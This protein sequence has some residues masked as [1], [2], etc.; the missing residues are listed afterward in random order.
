MA[1]FK[2]T[3]A[4]NLVISEPDYK[5]NNEELNEAYTGDGTIIN[6]DFLNDAFKISSLSF[7]LFK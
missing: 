1:Q 6:S 4:P 2:T 7:S 5:I 3:K